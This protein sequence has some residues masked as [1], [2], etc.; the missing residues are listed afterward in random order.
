MLVRRL[1][2][3]A[4]PAQV[5]AKQHALFDEQLERAVDRRR[6]HL[7]TVRP[8]ALDHVV[9][10]QVL[11]GLA[12]KRL[13]DQ[14]TLLG[15]PPALRAELAWAGARLVHVV[16]RRLRRRHAVM[17]TRRGTEPEPRLLRTSRN[18]G[19]RGLLQTTCDKLALEEVGSMSRW[20]KVLTR[21]EWLRLSGFGGAVL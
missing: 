9:R 18:T 1:E 17:M 2:I 4:A 20:T 21:A 14:L 10:A 15:Q 13:P 19:T 7:R 5:G 8:D 3:R 12:R 16:W 6:V 11:V